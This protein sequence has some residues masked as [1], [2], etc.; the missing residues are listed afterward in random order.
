[1]LLGE[2]RCERECERFQ[3]ENAWHSRLQ[4]DPL[5]TAGEYALLESW[6]EARHHHARLARSARPGHDE[7][8][9][10]AWARRCWHEKAP[11]SVHQLLNQAFAAKEIARVVLCEGAQTFVRIARLKGR[12]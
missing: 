9:G 2:P 8:A 7:Q 3:R 11:H 5:R 1:A 4:I 12:F 6:Q 10:H